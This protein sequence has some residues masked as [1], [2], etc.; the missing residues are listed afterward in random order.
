[1]LDLHKSL[2]L[3]VFLHFNRMEGVA[4]FISCTNV[5]SNTINVATTRWDIYNLFLTILLQRYIFFYETFG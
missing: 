4:S 2:F 3:V 5:E 1:M